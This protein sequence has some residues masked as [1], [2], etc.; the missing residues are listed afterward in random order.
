MKIELIQGDTSKT[1]KFQRK[2]IDGTPITTIA[3]KMWITF[4]YNQEKENAVFQKT[5]EN[6]I[7]YN[8]EDNYYRFRIEAE[9]TEKLYPGTYGFD[10]AIINEDGEKKTLYNNGILEI[11]DHYTKKVNEV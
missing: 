9:D 3:A 5:L 4:K 1:Y 7:I 10:I 6:G 11:L 8:E 2:T